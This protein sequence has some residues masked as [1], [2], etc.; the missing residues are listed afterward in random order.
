METQSPEVSGLQAQ[1][2]PGVHGDIKALVPFISAV[3]LAQFHPQSGFPWG[4]SNPGR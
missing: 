2:Y 1:C 4:C 3:S